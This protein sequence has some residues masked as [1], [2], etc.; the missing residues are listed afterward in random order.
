MYLNAKMFNS[1]KLKKMVRIINYKRE[2][3][4]GRILCLELQG[5]IEMVKSKETDKFYVNS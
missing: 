5:G 2:T 1:K 4:D 3:E